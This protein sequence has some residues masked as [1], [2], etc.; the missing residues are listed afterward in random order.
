[1]K[2]L[3]QV[4]KST[5]QRRE[6]VPSH[7]PLAALPK[8]DVDANLAAFHLLPNLLLKPDGGLQIAAQY[9]E[10]LR[11]AAQV[12]RGKAKPSAS[13]CT[14]WARIRIEAMKG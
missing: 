1:M 12:A 6:V 8:M 9:T 11:H 4:S 5:S 3:A 2:P 7:L 10:S 13:R 14:G